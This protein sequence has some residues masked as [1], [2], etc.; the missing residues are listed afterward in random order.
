M[1][2]IDHNLRRDLRYAAARFFLGGL[3]AG[4]AIR[5]IEEAMKTGLWRDEFLEILDSEPIL[6]EVTKPFRRCLDALGVAVDGYEEALLAIVDWHTRAIVS[7]KEV[8]LQSLFWDLEGFDF[9]ISWDRRLLDANDASVLWDLYQESGAFLFDD[10][11]PT[12]PD[13]DKVCRAYRLSIQQEAVRWQK[14][15]GG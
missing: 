6:R 10:S 4:D 1:S 9:S 7:G 2:A 14:A 3:R 13:R 15:R 11:D 12:R 8:W 5:T